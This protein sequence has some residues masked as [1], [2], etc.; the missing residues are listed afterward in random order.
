MEINMKKN[1]LR[2]LAAAM[3]LTTAMSSG[4]TPPAQAQA[5]AKDITVKAT[6]KMNGIKLAKANLTVHKKT[7]VQLKV[8]QGP[9]DVTA[10]AK[11]KSSNAKVISVN[12]K[13]KATFKKNGTATL[14]VKYGGKSKKLKV[15]VAKHSWKA[16]ATKVRTVMAMRY[17]CNCG[18]ILPEKEHKYCAKCKKVKKTKYDKGWCDCKQKEH[19]YGHKNKGEDYTYRTEYYPLNVKYAPSATCKGCGGKRVWQSIPV[20][21]ESKAWY[22][23]EGYKTFE[24][25]Y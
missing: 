18:E 21:Y 19:I 5:A 9:K 1:W 15:S 2:K 4:M 23:A 24:Y 22:E 12:R 16:N 25:D 7:A 20:H 17:R 6:T 11:Y 3:A 13:G 10:K 8:S 14:T